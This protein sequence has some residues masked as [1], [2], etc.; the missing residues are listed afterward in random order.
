MKI[1]KL[2]LKNK[3]SCALHCQRRVIKHV[4]QMGCT[5]FLHI[6]LCLCFLNDFFVQ[7]KYSV[8]AWIFPT[9]PSFN[10]INAFS[11]PMW[12]H[13]VIFSALYKNCICVWIHCG[14]VSLSGVMVYQALPYAQ[15]VVS[16]DVQ[17]TSLLT[18]CLALFPLGKPQHLIWTQFEESFFLN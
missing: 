18:L 16:A 15:S 11:S 9:K 14:F 12:H 5:T 8:K 17:L 1:I 4:Q 10:L 6:N 13:F 2:S 7:T 3:G